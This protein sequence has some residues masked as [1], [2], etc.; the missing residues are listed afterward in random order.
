MAQTVSHT[1]LELKRTLKWEVVSV[2]LA[3]LSVMIAVIYK[4]C[5]MNNKND[6][7]WKRMS[8]TVTKKV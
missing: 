5:G 4:D 1:V 7:K 2:G 3:R 8:Y 6:S